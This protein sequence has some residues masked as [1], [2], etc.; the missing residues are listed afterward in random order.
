MSFTRWF[1]SATFTGGLIALSLQVGGIAQSAPSSTLLIADSSSTSQKVPNGVRDAESGSKMQV[2]KDGSGL[3]DPQAN[4]IGGQIGTSYQRPDS[5][6]PKTPG[7]RLTEKSGGTGSGSDKPGARGGP[8]DS[9]SSGI[10]GGSGA[11]CCGK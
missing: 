9:S 4:T 1:V 10:S 6:T 3:T 7:S 8:G 11:G 5:D 2:D